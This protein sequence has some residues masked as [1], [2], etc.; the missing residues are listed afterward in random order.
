MKKEYFELSM[1]VA[2]PLFR[3]I[4]EA[5]PDRVA[6]DCPLAALQIH[7]GTGRTARHPIQILAKAYGLDPEHPA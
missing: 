6:T 4:G 2:E 1:K 3:E 5:K 7:Q